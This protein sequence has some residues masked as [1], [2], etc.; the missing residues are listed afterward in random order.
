MAEAAGVTGVNIT[1]GDYTALFA[2]AGTL[3]LPRNGQMGFRTAAEIG[4]AVWHAGIPAEPRTFRAA[5][6][7]G[8]R[9]AGPGHEFAGG[10]G[11]APSLDMLEL[12]GGTVMRLAGAAIIVAADG[13]SV[14]G[15][16]SSEYARLL[17]VYDVDAAGRLAEARHVPG[18]VF[19]L[20]SD[21]GDGNY[22]HWL[23][24]ELPRLALLRGRTDVTIVI[25]E[26]DAPWRRDLLDIVGIAPERIVTLGPH[27]ALR[28]DTLLIPGSGRDMQHPARKGAAWVFDW[29]RGEVALPALARSVPAARPKR[30][31]IGRGDAPGRRLLNQAALLRVLE[32]AGFASVTLAGMP[33][34]EQVALFA[35]AEAIV[36]LHGAGL[37]NLVFCDPGAS[38]IE[39]FTPGF[40][41]PCFGLVS[42]ANDLRHA[43]YCAEP[44]GWP[45]NGT[46]DCVLD[47]PG[48]WREA[49]PWLFGRR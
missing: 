23:I 18:T 1:S 37:T 45:P 49:E 7:L 26:I 9:R 32:P 3:G 12:P 5:D 4:G 21:V 8:Q 2:V 6:R 46:H 25:A 31:Y 38:V 36:A 48:F 14:A 20:M 34:A 16:V 40:G 13:V 27:D 43:T 30:L 28:A 19:V 17:H 44:G 22:C 24:D 10:D 47:V 42:A 35:G 11:V 41:N 33:V 15:E 29:L 39:I